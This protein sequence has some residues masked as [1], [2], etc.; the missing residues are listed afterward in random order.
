[1][2]ADFPAGQWCACMCSTSH[3]WH[4]VIPTPLLRSS[5]APPGC[6]PATTADP[7][8]MSSTAP[9]PHAPRAFLQGAR[10]MIPAKRVITDALRLLAYG[11]DASFYR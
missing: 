9:A 10:E 6:P 5:V 11:G 7:H 2:T 1:M 3:A 4:N 8:P